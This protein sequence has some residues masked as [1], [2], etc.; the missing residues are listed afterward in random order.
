MTSGLLLLDKPAGITSNAALGRVKR[1]LGVRKAGHAGT[2]DP[3]ATGLLV[4]CFGQATRVLAYLLEADKRYLASLHLGCA[5]STG[6]PEGE[7]LREAPVPELSASEWDHLLARFV[8]RV[9]QRPPMFSALKHQGRP[10]YEW[11]RAGIEVDRPCREVRVE[12][13]RC[14]RWEPPLLQFEALVGKGT[15]VRTLGEQIAETVGSVGYLSGL[16][17]TAVGDFAIDDAIGPEQLEAAVC[18][19][20]YLQPVDRALA[21]FDHVVLTRQSARRVLQGQPVPAPA[22]FA[23]GTRLRAYVEG[24]DFLGMVEAVA[25]GRLQPRRMFTQTPT[26]G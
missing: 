23:T 4:C 5:T 3:F 18:P 21:G 8:G 25:D 14:L 11:A 10:L 2:L 19:A 12:A 16:R 1:I 20:D 22:P 15:Y 7:V 9:Q 6:D 24:G 26:G 13:L 17:R